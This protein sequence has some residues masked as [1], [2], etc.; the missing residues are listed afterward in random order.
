[1]LASVLTEELGCISVK[2]GKLSVRIERAFC[3]E[4]GRALNIYQARAVYFNHEE[5]RSRLEFLCSDEARRARNATKVTGVNYDKAFEEGGDGVLVKPHFR[6][7]PKYTHI[8]GCE[9]L[10]REIA[11]QVGQTDGAPRNARLGLSRLRRLK[12]S[13]VVDVFLPRLAVSPGAKR[14]FLGVI[15]ISEGLMH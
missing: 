1:V 13:D 12:S 5:P 14:R 8:A 7:N 15:W 4:T 3:I 10:A 9:W 6:M 2:F 11:L